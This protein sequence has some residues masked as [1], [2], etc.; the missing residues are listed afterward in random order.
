MIVPIKIEFLPS[1]LEIMKLSYENTA[2]KFGMTEENCPYRGRTCLP[3]HVLEDEYNAG[4]MMYGYKQNEAIIGFLSLRKEQQIMRVND[5]AILPAYQN[6]GFGSTLIQFAIE[7]AKAQNCDRI[8]LGMVYDNVPLRKWYEKM[9]FRTIKLKK[10]EKV[11][12]QVATM[13][14]LLR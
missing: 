6:K 7:Q 3:Y 8:I 10:Y 14:L 11:N 12:Y 5:I 1:C 4:C 13:E 9:G 2:I